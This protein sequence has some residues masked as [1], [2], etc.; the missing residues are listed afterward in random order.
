VAEIISKMLCPYCRNP[1]IQHLEIDNYRCGHCNH[2]FQD[3]YVSGFNK[4][5]ADGRELERSKVGESVPKLK[6][7]SFELWRE[8]GRVIGVEVPAD[9]T[10]EELERTRMFLNLFDPEV[11]RE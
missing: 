1:L 11:P 8:S 7:I 2:Q 10:R 4:G 3:N 6:S 5:L 9:I